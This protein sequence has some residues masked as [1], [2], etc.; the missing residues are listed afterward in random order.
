MTHNCSSAA[1]RLW[2]VGLSVQGLSCVTPDF[3][4]APL[5]LS[6]PPNREETVPGQGDT[7]TKHNTSCSTSVKRQ[8]PPWLL[9]PS[10]ASHRSASA[11]LAPPPTSLPPKRKGSLFKRRGRKAAPKVCPPSG[12]RAVRALSQVPSPE[13]HKRGPKWSTCFTPS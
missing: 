10:P 11:S 6:R 5:H 9:L 7:H 1:P 3:I 8:G 13:F 12:E 2:F 4:Y